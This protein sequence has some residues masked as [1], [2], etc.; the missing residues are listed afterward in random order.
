[1]TPVPKPKRI[2][3]KKLLK[4][5]HD[6][7]CL[8]CSEKATPAHIKTRGSGGDDVDFNLM[9]LCRWHHSEQH[10]RGWKK[11]AGAHPR[12]AWALEARGWVIRKDGKMER[13]G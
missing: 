12:I 6:K 7:F 11:F 1:M 2:V 9:P 4:T 8:L 5:Y 10:A 3:D 13:V